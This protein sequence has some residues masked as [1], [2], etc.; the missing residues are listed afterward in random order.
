MEY[1]NLAQGKDKSTNLI[2][3]LLV[4]PNQL[5]YIF[6]YIFEFSVRFDNNAND[7]IREKRGK[8]AYFA[9]ER[10]CLHPRYGVFRIPI[11]VVAL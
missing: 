3:T 1:A 9:F 5:I 4:K 7:Q 2:L 11:A 10:I 8:Y 6:I